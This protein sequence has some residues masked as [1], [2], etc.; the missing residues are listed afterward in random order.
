M[1]LGKCLSLYQFHEIQV[2]EKIKYFTECV[3]TLQV[4]KDS[5][6]GGVSLEVHNSVHSGGVTLNKIKYIKGGN[7]EWEQ[8][9]SSQIIVAAGSK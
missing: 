5:G 1:Y 3:C 8:V 9:L 2:E 7:T 6:E 4:I